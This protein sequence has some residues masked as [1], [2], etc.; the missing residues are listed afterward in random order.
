MALSEQRALSVY[1]ICDGSECHFLI[2]MWLCVHGVVSVGS[3]Q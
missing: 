2:G 1:G 3:E